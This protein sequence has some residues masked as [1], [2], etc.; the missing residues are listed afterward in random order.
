MCL[1]VEPEINLKDMEIELAILPLKVRADAETI[2]LLELICLKGD[3]EFFELL[4]EEL[5]PAEYY[6]ELCIISNKF[7]AVTAFWSIF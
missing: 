3:F 4:K 7:Q 1:A 6:F 2:T 5:E